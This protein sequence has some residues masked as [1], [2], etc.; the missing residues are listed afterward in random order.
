MTSLAAQN[1]HLSCKKILSVLKI[2]LNRITILNFKVI[3]P[4]LYTKMLKP[5]KEELNNKLRDDLKW[6]DKLRIEQILHALP[7]IKRKQLKI[8]S[9]SRHFSLAI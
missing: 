7:T 3:R 8:D 5:Q 4:F 9:L 1:N 2:P 6:L